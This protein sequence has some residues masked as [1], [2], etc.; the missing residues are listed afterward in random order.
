MLMKVISGVR[1]LP[2]RLA[3]L[4]HAW[5]ADGENHKKVKRIFDALQE[6]E[7]E[8]WLDEEQLTP[9]CRIPDVIQTGMED[10]HCV[11]VF[12]TRE[13]LDKI[14]NGDVLQDFCRMEFTRAIS[15]KKKLVTVVMEAECR[16]ARAWTGVEKEHL[17]ELLYEDFSI[18]LEEDFQ[19]KCDH[20][21]ASLERVFYGNPEA[22]SRSSK[23]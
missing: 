21:Y 1:V 19:A 17:S 23:A 5:G 2:R 15:M 7:L 20:L 12:I 10:S 18:V 3:F 4:S 6:R 22:D 13:Y 14:N 11:V 16:S 8:F 9:G